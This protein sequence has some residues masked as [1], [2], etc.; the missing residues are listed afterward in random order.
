MGRPTLAP[1]ERR[2]DRLPNLRVTAAER[3]YVEEQA[4]NAG[5]PLAEFC[6]RAILSKRIAPRLTSADERLLVEVNKA[7]VNL[8]QIARAVNGGRG[9]PPDFSEVLAEVDA[10]LKKVLA[11]GS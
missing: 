3:A 5:L 9:L 6:R 2:D 7:G 11:N 10:A 4:A 1:E 8:N